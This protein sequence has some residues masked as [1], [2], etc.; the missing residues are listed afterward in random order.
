[1]TD[2]MEAAMPV[3]SPERIW[4]ESEG[5]CPYFYHE[6]ELSDVDS[7]VTEYVRS[8][9]LR[10]EI[11]ALR[12]EVA[13]WKRVAAAQAELHGEAEERADKLAAVLRL[14]LD[15]HG[16]LLMTD[17]LQDA[18]EVHRVEEIGRALLRDQEEDHEQ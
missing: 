4:I 3:E 12:A 16:V 7:P 9:K 17:P 10:S 8:D 18:W 13:E 2:R 15:S 6:E 11:E 14:A 1:M 5:G